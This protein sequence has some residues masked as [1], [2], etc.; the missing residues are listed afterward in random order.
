MVFPPLCG[1]I[2]HRTP[3]RFVKYFLCR[4]LLQRSPAQAGQALSVRVC[5]TRGGKTRKGNS[6]F[7]LRWLDREPSA[8]HL[9]VPPPAARRSLGHIEGSEQ[10]PGASS[11]GRMNQNSAIARKLETSWRAW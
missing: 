4:Y 3:R 11:L 7:A 10:P 2:R 5:V 1:E 9:V 6:W 8:D